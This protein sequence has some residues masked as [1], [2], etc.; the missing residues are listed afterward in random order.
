[1]SILNKLLFIYNRPA[2][3]SPHACRELTTRLYRCQIFNRNIPLPKIFYAF[4]IDNDDVYF[5][6]IA[7]LKN[8]TICAKH[9][10][11]PHR[12]IFNILR[13]YKI[14]RTFLLNAALKC[15]P[16]LR[17]IFKTCPGLRE[18]AVA[19]LSRFAENISRHLFGVP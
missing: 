16:Y 18:D 12:G 14:I 11:S 3:F 6:N 8:T 9:P 4:S 5:A 2:Y 19:S 15:E 13:S 10:H 7:L 17:G 1:M